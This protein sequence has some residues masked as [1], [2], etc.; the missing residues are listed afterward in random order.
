MRAFLAGIIRRK[1]MVYR[2]VDLSTGRI[3]FHAVRL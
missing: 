2:V 1:L 3:S